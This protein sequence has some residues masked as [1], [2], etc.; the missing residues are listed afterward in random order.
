MSQPLHLS[1]MGTAVHESATLQQAARVRELQAAGQRVFNFTVGE[2]DFG[3]PDAVHR[4]AH[5]A[6]DAGHTRYTST[7]GE[8]E[9]R[10]ALAAHYAARH[11]IAWKPANAIIGTGAK[12]VLFNAL[13]S[14]VDPGD[15][16]VLLSPYWTSYPAYVQLLGGVPRV[17]RTRPE[18]GFKATAADLRAVIN[19]KTRALVFN[20]PVNPTGV[21]YTRTEL[22]ELFA[23]LVDTDVVVVSDEIY[24]RMV[25]DGEHVSPLQAVPELA[26][27][28]LVV[29]GASKTFAMT[30]WRIGF[31]LGP[32]PLVEAMIRVQSHT[33]GNPNSV[34]QRAALAAL[35]LPPAETGPMID[36]FRQ[37]RD[38]CVGVLRTLPE[39]RF[40]EP[41]GAFYLFL[42]VE[43]FYGDWAGGRSIRTSA[44]LAAYLL[45]AHGVAV[46]PGSAFDYDGGI[47]V[48]Y[49]L[50]DEALR[51]GLGL[52]VRSLR[53]RR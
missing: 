24:E 43:P 48:S 22:A 36:R 40:P 32:V 1:R 27:R 19:R 46:V 52:L 37:R 10:A 28:F 47:R 30:G 35:A 49:T 15:E 23:P 45:E 34:A 7:A 12:Q 6:I 2:P 16:V 9:L 11:G 29:S 17:V 41:A 26:P 25:F 51:E 50:S 14:V 18:N 44:E 31:G 4:A 21:V 38:L 53:E 8:P 39:L 5:A 20:T 13:A 33:T 3:P 42:N